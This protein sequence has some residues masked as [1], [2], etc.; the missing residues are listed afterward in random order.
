MAGRRA[1]AAGAGSSET[2]YRVLR[3]RIMTCELAP[4]QLLTERRNAV[5]LGLGLP[6]VHDALTRLVRDGLVRTVSP[7]AYRVTP[8]TPKSV[9]DLLTAWAL[10]GP[11]V[12]ALGISRADPQQA[13]ELRRL[14]AHGTAVLAGSLDQ[15]RIVRFMDITERAF[16]LLAVA[17]RNDQLIEVYRSFAGELRRVVTLILIAAD[18]VDMLLAAGATWDSAFDRR[19]A[20]AATQITRDVTAAHHASALRV[21]G[22]RP[23]F[24]DGVVVPLWR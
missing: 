6:P 2:V 11:E 9:N 24:G 22:D 4:G 3:N 10:L 17:S 12:A 13:A 8:L 23:R 15:D 21:L 16:D 18:S 5:E 1:L 19:D 20:R 7:D 14:M